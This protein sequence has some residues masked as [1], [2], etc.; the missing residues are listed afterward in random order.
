M[1]KSF[2]ACLYKEVNGALGRVRCMLKCKCWEEC[3]SHGGYWIEGEKV[4]SIPLGLWFPPA[5]FPPRVEFNINIQPSLQQ[6]CWK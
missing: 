2:C 4:I 1:E 6:S 5:A 3:I